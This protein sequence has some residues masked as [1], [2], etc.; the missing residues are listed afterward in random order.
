LI[1]RDLG[2]HYD[3]RA[4]EAFSLQGAALGRDLH[5]IARGS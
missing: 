5:E 1:P 3:R 4:A 2:R